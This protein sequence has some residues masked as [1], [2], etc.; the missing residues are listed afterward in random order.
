MTE[1]DALDCK[2]RELKEWQRMAWHRIAEPTITRFEM[3]EIRNHLRESDG[4]LRRCL[5]MMSDRLRFEGRKVEDVGSSFTGNRGGA[6]ERSA[7]EIAGGSIVG[8]VLDSGGELV[9][10]D[11]FL[12]GCRRARR[13]LHGA[14]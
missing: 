12:A 10:L 14:I 4:E 9:G 1:S 13:G 8:R 5:A 3:R 7:D 11:V 6:L 2:I